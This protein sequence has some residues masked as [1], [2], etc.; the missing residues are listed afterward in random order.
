MK[1]EMKDM[2]YNNKNKDIYVVSASRAR[3]AGP[4]YAIDFALYPCLMPVMR[5]IATSTTITGPVYI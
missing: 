3:V 5:R 1:N 4:R 2:K